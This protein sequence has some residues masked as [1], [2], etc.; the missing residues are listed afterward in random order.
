MIKLVTSLQTTLSC[1]SP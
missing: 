1:L